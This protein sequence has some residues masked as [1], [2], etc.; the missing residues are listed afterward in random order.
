MTR[1][2]P[3]RG[4]GGWVT[5]SQ[6]RIWLSFVF[7][8]PFVVNAFIQ[9]WFQEPSRRLRLHREIPDRALR[10]RDDGDFLP[11]FYWCASGMTVF[12]PGFLRA[13]RAFVVYA[14]IPPS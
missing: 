6:R 2:V 12:L 13:L 7:F 11:G 10:V 8:V 14:F 1:P 4:L 9:L 5:T 3:G